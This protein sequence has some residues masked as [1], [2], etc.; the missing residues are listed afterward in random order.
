MEGR[1][2]NTHKREALGE[3]EWGVWTTVGLWVKAAVAHWG[4]RRA[5]GTRAP[6]W[7]VGRH[8]EATAARARPT[9]HTM[10]HKESK[11]A[12]KRGVGV[13]KQHPACS[14]ERHPRGKAE[15]CDC[16]RYN[17]SKK[18]EENKKGASNETCH[19]INGAE[20]IRRDCE[21]VH[22]RWSPGAGGSL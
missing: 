6:R 1:H 19:R 21:P 9:Q 16:I 8:P 4:H 5:L 3:R 20:W 12:S 18:S 22:G 15:G 14:L 7:F 17:S 10:T 13:T 11:R 2:T